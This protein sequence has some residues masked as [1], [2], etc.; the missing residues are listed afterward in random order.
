MVYVR[1]TDTEKVVNE[2]L[3]VLEENK[4]SIG[5]LDKVLSDVR[6]S[7]YFNTNIQNPKDN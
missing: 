5:L 7:A 6:E 1:E 3:D 4:V 2:I